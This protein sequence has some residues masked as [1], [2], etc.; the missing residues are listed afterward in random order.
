MK[1]DSV[2]VCTSKEM[3]GIKDS[4]EKC[5]RITLTANDDVTSIKIHLLKK[6]IESYKEEQVPYNI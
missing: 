4:T 2:F 5:T 1:G 6:L 3:C